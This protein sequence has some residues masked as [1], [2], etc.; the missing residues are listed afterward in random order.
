MGLDEMTQLGKAEWKIK[1][2]KKKRK[3]QG[4]LRVPDPSSMNHYKIQV[5]FRAA[6]LNVTGCGGGYGA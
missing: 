4:L 2:K 3:A 1:K 6:T 5:H